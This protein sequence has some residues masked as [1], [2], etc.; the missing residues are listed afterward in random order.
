MAANYRI[1]RLSRTE[2]LSV[3]DELATENPAFAEAGFDAQM[4][5][6][7]AKGLV[8]GDSFTRA[9]AGLG[10]EAIEVICNA[11]MVQKAW[12]RD[13][14]VA[15]DEAHWVRQILCAQVEAFRPDVI[16]IQGLTSNDTGFLPEGGF[17][18]RYPFV[19]AVMGFAG[20]FHPADRLDGIDFVLSGLPS[21]ER[22]YRAGGVATALVY[23]GFDTALVDCMAARP[24]ATW[25]ISATPP[26]RPTS[27]ASRS[28]ATR[29][30]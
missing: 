20:F 24:S 5:A 23:H 19:K 6:Y 3:F 25:L 22:Y 11:E 12:A 4:A 17:R 30:R 7:F 1:L 28:R 21:L 18:D 15:Y 14:G 29:R 16:F 26:A 9:M 8:Y 13:H 2:Y 10:N 27:W